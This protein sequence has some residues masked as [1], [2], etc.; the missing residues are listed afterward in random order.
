MDYYLG[1]VTDFLR[2]DRATFVNTEC[3]IEL[4]GTAVAMKRTHWHCDAVAVNLREEKIYLCEVTYSRTLEALLDRLRAWSTSW[5]AI[6]QAVRRD[7]CVP[8]RFKIRPWV[9]IPDEYRRGLPKKKS[10]QSGDD[11]RKMP[12]PRI[13]SLEDVAAWKYASNQEAAREKIE[14]SASR[15]QQSRIKPRAMGGEPREDRPQRAVLCAG[16]PHPQRPLQTA[17]GTRAPGSR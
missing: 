1:V 6:C 17:A 13:T 12:S 4:A 9:F 16:A 14:F 8:E 15:R 11:Y 7:C 2:T 5:P 10:L 3:S